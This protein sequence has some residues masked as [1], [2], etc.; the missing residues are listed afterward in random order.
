M[1]WYLIR[2]GNM[3]GDPHQHWQPPA[4][5]CLS[6]TGVRQAI[7]L[8]ENLDNVVF[9]AVFSSP[10]GRAIQTAQA[11]RRPS[12]TAIRVLD[13]LVEWRPANLDGEIA[14]A[15]FEEMMR[16]AAG[17]RPEQA[18]K[19]PAGEGALEM[20]ARIVPGWID[21]LESLGVSAGHGGYL[22]DNPA[23]ERNIAWVAHGGSLGVLLGFILGIPFAPYPPIRFEETGVAVL[24]LAAR[25]DVW[26]P[27]L[28]I[29]PPGAQARPMDINDTGTLRPVKIKLRK[30]AV[31]A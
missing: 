24:T 1:K 10:L 17:L 8:Q 27:A 31:R 14:P 20:A 19:T 26:Y 13:W 22:L 21:C 25:T 28:E 18:W 2:H 11:L 29:R 6:T 7:A 23:D 5:G 3:A 9:D 16:D 4:Q 30:V 15:R 12:G